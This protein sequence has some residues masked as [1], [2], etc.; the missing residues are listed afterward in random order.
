[1][2]TMKV[3][4]KKVSKFLW[5]R[6]VLDIGILIPAI[7]PQVILDV[8]KVVDIGLL[9]TATLPQINMKAVDIHQV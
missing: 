1:M 7:I 8:V 2:T 5:L 4:K 6:N 9:R 3:L